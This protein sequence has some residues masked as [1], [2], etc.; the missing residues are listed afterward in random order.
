MT[1]AAWRRA[2]AHVLH[3]AKINASERSLDKLDA[4]GP[5][6]RWTNGPR[7]YKGRAYTWRKMVGVPR[8]LTSFGQTIHPFPP[9]DS[10][11]R[12]ASSTGT[13]GAPP[14]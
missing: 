14:D 6:F 13:H 2:I 9:L 12:L 3:A 1:R 10:A 5:G 8:F 4:L 7:G 11:G